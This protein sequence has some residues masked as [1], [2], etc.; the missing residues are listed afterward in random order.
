MNLT[1]FEQTSVHS[2]FDLVKLLAAARGVEIA[3]S[4]LIGLL[5]R[6]AVESAFAHFVKL[7]LF[8][9]NHVIENR[10]NLLRIM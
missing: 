5:P 6:Q 1:D 10:L 4:E 2:V 7:P 8:D 9:S 3:D